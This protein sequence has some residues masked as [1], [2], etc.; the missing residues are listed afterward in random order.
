MTD[1]APLVTLTQLTKANLSHIPATDFE[2]LRFW[3]NMERLNVAWTALNDWCVCAAMLRLQEL[4]LDHER[5]EPTAQF[6]VLD[7]L[8]RLQV[9]VVRQHRG[10]GAMEDW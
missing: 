4:V 2:T 10:Y 5:A 9:H 6:A 8:E 3:T 7:H 1:L